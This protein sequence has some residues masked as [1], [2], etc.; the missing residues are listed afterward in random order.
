MGHHHLLSVNFDH[1]KNVFLRHR[2]KHLHSKIITIVPEDD[3]SS[4][5]RMNRVFMMIIMTIMAPAMATYLFT[6]INYHDKIP[7]LLAELLENPS[8]ALPQPV[9]SWPVIHNHTFSS[10]TIMIITMIIALTF[11]RPPVPAQ[12]GKGTHK[13]G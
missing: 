4:L 10:I 6:I 7:S 2:G 9:H 12:R 13:G 1:R 3:D 8:V 5:M 11:Q